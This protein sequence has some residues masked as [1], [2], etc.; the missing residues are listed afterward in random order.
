M[1]ALTRNTMQG[2]DSGKGRRG[3]TIRR[4]V[5]GIA[6]FLLLLPLLAMQFSREVNWNGS[7]FAVMGFML[8]TAC[9][10]YEFAVWLSSNIAYRAAFGIALVA[11]F[12]LVWLNL[13]IG[14][15]GDENNPPNLMFA[16]VLAVGFIGAM[17][18]RFRPRGM[19]RAMVATAYSQALVG[20]IAVAANWGYE[21]AALGIFFCAMWLTSAVLFR[22]AALQHGQTLS[23]PHSR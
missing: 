8:L 4:L 14:I 20:V 11:S 12:I 9:A 10:T 17:I 19:S 21:A 23:S 7:D 18:A 13:A 16:G 6:A 1:Q 22:K 15:I 5:W 2:S 3:N